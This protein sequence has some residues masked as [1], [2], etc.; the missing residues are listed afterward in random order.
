MFFFNGKKKMEISSHHLIVNI[1]KLDDLL[2]AL[3]PSQ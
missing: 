3:T 2:N 1:F